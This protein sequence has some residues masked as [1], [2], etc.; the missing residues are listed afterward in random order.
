MD[1][2]WLKA[3]S[4]RAHV[5]V[6]S[7]HDKMWRTLKYNDRLST[8]YG[9]G[10]NVVLSPVLSHHETQYIYIYIYIL[11]VARARKPLSR[12]ARDV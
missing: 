8:E 3:R 6:A 2:D 7:Y 11:S 10:P 9:L 4:T 12:Y 5:S 1:S